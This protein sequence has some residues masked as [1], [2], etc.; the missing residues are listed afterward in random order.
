MSIKSTLKYFIIVWEKLINPESRTRRIYDFIDKF[1]DRVD[2]HNDFLMAAG[3]SYSILLYLFPLFLV[4]VFV[5]SQIFDPQA[6][7]DTLQQILSKL[8]PPTNQTHQLLNEII[9]EVNYIFTKSAIAGWVG[10][11]VLLWVSSAFFSS[12]RT[13]LNVIMEIPTPKFFIIYKLKDILITIV[14]TLLLLISTFIFPLISIIRVFLLQFL[15]ETIEWIFSWVIV[16]SVS[17]LTSFIFFYLLYRFVPNAR[18][19]RRVRIMSTIMAVIFIEIS[20]NI[21]AWYL[22]SLSNFGAFYG[23]YAVVASIALWIYYLTLIILL[24]AELSKYLYDIK[25]LQKNVKTQII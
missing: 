5:V 18:T 2:R 1:V 16:F 11:F 24:S 9:T 12:L 23:S 14:L 25:Q 20:R 4:S 6:L 8:L 19:P 13:G 10:V 17:I 3:I 7:T 22:S 15:P 21:F